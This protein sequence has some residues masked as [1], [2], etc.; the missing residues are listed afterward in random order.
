MVWQQEMSQQESS[1]N[2]DSD[3]HSN[4]Y[5]QFQFLLLLFN[6]QLEHDQQFAGEQALNQLV[7]KL[8]QLP[9]SERE[10]QLSDL[11]GLAPAKLCSHSQE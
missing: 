11:L 5:C 6:I 9:L 2:N 8:Q 10:Q 7:L 3:A 4:R 1:I